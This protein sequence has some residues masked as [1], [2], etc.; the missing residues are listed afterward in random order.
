AAVMV[1]PRVQIGAAIAIGPG[2]VDLLRA[3]ER[4]RSISAAARTMGLT[5]K[6]AW[7]LV[8]SLNQGF[9]QPVVAAT[10]GGR[11]GGGAMLTPLGAAL[12]ARYEALEAKLDAACAAELQAFRDLPWARGARLDR[13]NRRF[14]PEAHEQANPRRTRRAPLLRGADARPYRSPLPILPS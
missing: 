12:V 1:R 10:A 3:I 2:K 13:H 5:Y 9:G 4:E 6:R 14:A 7:L 8:D 11:G